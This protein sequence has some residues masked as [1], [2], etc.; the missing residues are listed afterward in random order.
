[1]L[2][3]PGRISES[4]DVLSA[5]IGPS[6]T[7]P[8]LIVDPDAVRSLPIAFELF[9]TI[10]ECECEGHLTAPRFRVGEACDEPRRQYWQNALPAGLWTGLRIN[11]PP[12]KTQRTRHA[13]PN[14]LFRP[15]HRVLYGLNSFLLAAM[16]EMIQ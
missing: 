16:T 6:E 9:Q 14:V 5:G 10:S 15:I 12:Y 7:H 13:Q 8:E 4:I 3:T 2:V 11:Y 1:L